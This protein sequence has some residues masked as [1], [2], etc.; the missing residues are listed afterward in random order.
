M[1]VLV[2]MVKVIFH[3]IFFEF[4]AI[5]CSFVPYS[6]QSFPSL[7]KRIS[8]VRAELILNYLL[9]LISYLSKSPGMPVENLAFS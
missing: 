1:L 3:L 5:F 2:V 7:S 4:S 6:K 9:I 8:T